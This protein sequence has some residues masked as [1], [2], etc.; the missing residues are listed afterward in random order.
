MDAEL[1]AS[2]RALRTGFKD[3]ALFDEA[4]T[5]LLATHRAAELDAGYLAYDEVPA[6]QADAW[7]GLR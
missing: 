5:A 4:L 3:H 6:D 2:A 7:G 1:L